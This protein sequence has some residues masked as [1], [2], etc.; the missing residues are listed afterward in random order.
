VGV[1]SLSRYARALGLGCLSGVALGNEKTGLIPTKAWKEKVLGVPWQAGETLSTAIGQSFTLV[2]PLQTLVMMSAIANN[3]KICVPQLVKK[4]EDYQGNVKKDFSP[5]FISS[6]IPISAPSLSAV[7][8]ALRRVV[9]NPHGTGKIARIDGVE[10]AGKTGTAQVVSL[11]TD[12]KKS[13]LPF[14][15]RDHAWFTAFAPFHN[16]EIA[17]VVLIEHGG[18]GSGAA[19]PLA[20]E[21]IAFYLNNITQRSP[22]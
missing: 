6:P 11:P 19:A 13:E 15:L 9:Q 14:H 20:R 12:V 10:V 4:I 17:V 21:L 3:G 7:R 8:E 22:R 16:P 18:S 1:D 2:T 5:Q